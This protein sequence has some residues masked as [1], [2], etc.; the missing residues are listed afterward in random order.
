MRIPNR[1]IDEWLE[2]N[3]A[4][5]LQFQVSEPDFIDWQNIDWVALSNPP[6]HTPGEY[7][8]ISPGGEE[9]LYDFAT[10]SVCSW[11]WQ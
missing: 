3:T 1:R 10:S 9:G 11:P 7:Y 8:D 2:T 5:P 6:G 4:G